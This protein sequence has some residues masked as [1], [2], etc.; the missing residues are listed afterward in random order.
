MTQPEPYD[1]ESEYRK[2]GRWRIIL[3]GVLTVVLIAMV[4]AFLAWYVMA[5]V[6]GTSYQGALGELEPQA[7]SLRDALRQHVEQLAVVIGERNLDNYPALGQAADYIQEQLEAAGY[8]VGRQ[9]YRVRGLAC[10]NL[11]VEIA[12]TDKPEQ[13]V[14]IGA[15]YDTAPTTP[16]ANDNASGVAAMLE[17][18]RHFAKHQSQRTLRFVAFVNEEPPYF[19]TE[20][21]GSLVYAQRCHKR[22]EDIVAMISL[23]TIGYYRDEPGTQQYP[24]PF[25]ALYPDRGN[26]VGV[27]SN[28]ASRPLLHRVIE[29]FR[30]H[31][32][33]P[34]QGGAIPSSVPGVG[35]SDHW[36]FWQY[37]YPA[38]MLTDTAPFRYPY[39]H[40]P[41]DTPDKLNFEHMARVVEGVKG[42]IADLTDTDAL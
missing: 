25:G 27:V 40:L 26:F 32:Q 28:V 5:F 17:L 39:Y 30:R 15:H 2:P 35:W 6:P 21:M 41:Q 18:A 24:P 23:E 14:V 34:S 11:E 7:M 42:V 36:S 13:I 31:A 4:G 22:N 29:S 9:P 16:G 1:A 20:L 19:Q 37:G 12:G 10:D 3:I 33:F 8:S 38:V